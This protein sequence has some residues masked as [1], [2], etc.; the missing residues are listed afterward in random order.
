MQAH[1]SHN[2]SH[3]NTQTFAACGVHVHIDKIT[4]PGLETEVTHVI[5]YIKTVQWA[6]KSLS[7]LRLAQLPVR[8]LL[9]CTG[10]WRSVC[11]NIHHYS[12]EYILLH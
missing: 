5:I 7:M 3:C 6:V 11:E 2:S 12:L 9:L 8:I 4:L 1:P 10:T